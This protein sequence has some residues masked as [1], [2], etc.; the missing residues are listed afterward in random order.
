VLINE[1]AGAAR[2]RRSATGAVLRLALALIF[3]G[4]VTVIAAYSVQGKSPVI[5]Q[6]G[7]RSS[8]VVTAQN[9]VVVGS[10]GTVEDTPLYISMLTVPRCAQHHCE[11][12]NSRI[13]DGTRLVAICFVLGAGMTNMN[14]G[15]LSTRKNP[16]R[17]TSD[18]WYGIRTANGRFGYVSEVYLTPKSR[19]GLDLR[20]CKTA[21]RTALDKQKAGG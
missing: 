1:A 2:V 15:V 18:I 11:L 16:A 14:L 10:T 21:S 4:A 3:L 12:P 9:R 19:G 13:A 5:P 8:A 17:I 20:K 6:Y 7:S